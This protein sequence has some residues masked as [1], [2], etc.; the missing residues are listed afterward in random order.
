METVAV[1]SV[2]HKDKRKNIPTEPRRGAAEND[3]LPRDP[4]LDPQPGEHTRE[5]LAA[6]GLSAEE[7]EALIASRVARA[8]KWLR[9]S[10]FGLTSPALPL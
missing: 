3:S 6:A 2:R 8:G 1:D 10:C 7:I 4:L 5:I 9:D